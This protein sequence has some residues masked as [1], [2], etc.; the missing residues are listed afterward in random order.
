[1]IRP[2]IKKISHVTQIVPVWVWACLLPKANNRY[3]Y[4]DTKFEDHASAVKII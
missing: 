1:M 3:A 4:M 2:H